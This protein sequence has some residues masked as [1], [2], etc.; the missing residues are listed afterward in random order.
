[1][2][3]GEG[4]QGLEAGIEMHQPGLRSQEVGSNTYERAIFPS[5]QAMLCIDN[6]VVMHHNL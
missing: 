4:E 5:L 1:M 2:E 6:L 3:Q